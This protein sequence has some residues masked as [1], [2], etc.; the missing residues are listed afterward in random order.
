MYILFKRT[1]NILRIDHMLSYKAS[2]S[3][4]KKFEIISNLFSSE[5]AMSLVI[6]CRQEFQNKETP[7]LSRRLNNLL[8]YY[9]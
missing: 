4:F 3:E 1:W 2:S 5:N 6:N 9:Q 7:T 8:H